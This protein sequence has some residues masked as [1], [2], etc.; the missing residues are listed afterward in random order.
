M[1]YKDCRRALKIVAVS[2]HRMPPRRTALLRQTA[3][4]SVYL[5]N[6][7]ALKTAPG[8]RKRFSDM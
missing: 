3:L 4:Q 8:R 1:S 2:A 6:A 7:D 5:A